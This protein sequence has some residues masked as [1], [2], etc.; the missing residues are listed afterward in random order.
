M[1]SKDWIER[2]VRAVMLPPLALLIASGVYIGGLALGSGNAVE[3]LVACSATFNANV[4]STGFLVGYLVQRSP[5][6]TR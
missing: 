3:V 1:V 4:V 5:Q 6:R 2:S